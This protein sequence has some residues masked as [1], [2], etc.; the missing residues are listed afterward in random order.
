MKKLNFGLIGAGDIVRKRVAQALIDNER[1]N[2]LSVNR[3]NEN[4]VKDFAK[5]YQIPR[6]YKSWN[7]LINDE[8]INAVYLATPVYLH[9]SQTIAAAEAGK[10]VLCEKPMGLNLSECENMISAAEANHIKL[11][12]AYYRHFYPVISR[13]KE[14]LETGKIGKP[15]IAFVRAFE[16]FNPPKEH[17]R[18]WLLEKNKSGGGPMFDFGCHRIEVLINLFGSIRDVKSNVDK[19]IYEREVEDTAS[20]LIRF[21]S[22]VQSVLSVT[23]AV[24]ESSDTL[25][26]YCTE[27][28]I[29]ISNLN[30]GNLT[31]KTV[32]GE[33]SE[34]LKPHP[35]FHFPLIDDFVDSILENRK[36]AVSAET[37]KEVNKI[38]DMIYQK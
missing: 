33:K 34:L 13:V 2:L 16:H 22:S 12:I 38:L 7:D 36:P 11:G 27:G 15:V 23:H 19:V 6:W 21:D 24:H 18:Y 29:H 32:N 28:S 25:E 1:I 17:L 20:V 10:H 5:E 4:G 14:I 9:A 37:G 26:I 30:E 3:D 31:L 35:N 8:E